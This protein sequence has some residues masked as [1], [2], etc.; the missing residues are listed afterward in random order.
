ML[1]ERASLVTAGDHRN[2][3]LTC[4]QPPGDV[5]ADGTGAVHTDLHQSSLRRSVWVS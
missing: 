3:S 2:L 5:A 4:G 1:L